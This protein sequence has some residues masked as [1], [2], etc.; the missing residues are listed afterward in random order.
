MMQVAPRKPRTEG[1][2]RELKHAVALPGLASLRAPSS[3]HCSGALRCCASPLLCGRHGARLVA[4]GERRLL[5]RLPGV[6]VRL[7]RCGPAQCGAFLLLLRAFLP[8]LLDF[9]LTLSLRFRLSSLV[10]YICS[11]WR[12]TS[13]LHLK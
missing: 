3:P 10:P 8:S 11:R 13:D 2:R 9:V 5:L 12:E 6:R 7:R 4:R 1:G